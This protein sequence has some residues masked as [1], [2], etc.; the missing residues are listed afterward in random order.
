MRYLIDANAL[1]SLGLQDHAVHNA[2]AFLLDFCTC[3]PVE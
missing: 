2:K 1:I 3:F